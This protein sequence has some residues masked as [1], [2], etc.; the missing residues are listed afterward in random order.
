MRSNYTYKIVKLGGS[1]ITFK[2]RPMSIRYDVVRY[3]ASELAYFLSGY[4]D[5]R[6]VLIHGGGSFGHPVVHECL[7]TRGEIDVECFSKTS[8]TMMS[9]NTYLI[10]ELNDVGI[11]SVSIPPHTIFR[12]EV[13]RLTY[14]SD[15]IRKYLMRGL[16][17]VLYGDVILSNGSFEVISGDTIAWLLAKDLSVG[18]LIFVTDVDGLFDKDPKKYA[19]AKLIDFIHA[20][21]L[22]ELTFSTNEYDVTGSMGL[23]L[24]EGLKYD[25]RGVKVRVV[26]GLIRGNLYKSLV[27][28]STVGTVVEY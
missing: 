28:G 21:S 8:Y 17:P 6:L 15:L 19:D 7:E 22:A 14:E 3:L 10:K 23:K 2:D 16:T 27:G 13:G 9:L 4:P 25:V 20:S 24:V 1:V 5:T 26:N 11:K 12:R 18:E